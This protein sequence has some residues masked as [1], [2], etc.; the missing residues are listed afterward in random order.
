MLDHGAPEHAVADPIESLRH[1]M[2]HSA[3]HVMADAARSL[4]YAVDG[5]LN[6]PNPEGK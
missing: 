6:L 4:F 5:K 2:R 3:A 1:R